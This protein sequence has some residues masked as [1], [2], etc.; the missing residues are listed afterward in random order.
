MPRWPTAGLTPRFVQGRRY[1]DPATMEIVARVLAEEICGG[2]AARNRRSQGGKAAPLHYG[3]TPVL[4]G[5]TACS[6]PNGS[7]G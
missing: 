2:L 6:L 7:G 3:T 4:D 5:E 1:T